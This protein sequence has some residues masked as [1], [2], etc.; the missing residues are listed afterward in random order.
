MRHEPTDEEWTAIRPML[1]NNA[2]GVPR[3]DDRLVLNGI[4]WV[5]R[6]GGRPAGQLSRDRARL[7]FEGI[8]S[9]SAPTPSACPRIHFPVPLPDSVR[10][11]RLCAG[12]LESIS[13][14]LIDIDGRER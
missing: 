6:S 14:I 7:P 11:D 10:A 2:R 13:A 3:A 9:Y 4:F 12:F 8:G 1:P 5:M